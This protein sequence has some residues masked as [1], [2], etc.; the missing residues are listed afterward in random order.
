[1]KRLFLLMASFAISPLLGL[2]VANPMDASLYPNGFCSGGSLQDPCDPHFRWSDKFQERIGFY[3]DYVFNRKL[4]VEGGENISKTQIMTNAGLMVVNICN[5]VDVFWTLGGT[6]IECFS[7]GSRFSTDSTNV[8]IEFEP[9]FSWSIGG[10]ASLCRWRRF[11]VGIEGQFF[12]TRPDIHKFIRDGDDIGANFSSKSKSAY[13]QWQVGLGVSYVC[14]WIV[15]YAAFKAS[16]A[17]LNL[18]DYRFDFQP[19]NITYVLHNLVEQSIYGCAVGVTFPIRETAGITL[20]GR[21]VDENAFT[22]I[23][24]IRF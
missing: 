17:N 24:E 2:P 22:V 10:R 21:F 16:K 11:Y 19:T 18:D 7:N 12:R 8:A 14:K 13:K 1:M 9:Y 23:G 20:E 3:G 6:S 5:R 15:P 4:S